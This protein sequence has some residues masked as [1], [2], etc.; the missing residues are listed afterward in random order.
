[1]EEMNIA[2]SLTIYFHLLFFS[3][4]LLV[5]AGESQETEAEMSAECA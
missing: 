5:Q 2:L 3:F 1:M 4:S